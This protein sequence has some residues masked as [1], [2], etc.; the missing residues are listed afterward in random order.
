MSHI[1]DKSQ[2]HLRTGRNGIPIIL[3]VGL[4]LAMM[5]SG[6]FSKVVF[7]TLLGV[8]LFIVTVS[9]GFKIYYDHKL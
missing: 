6:Y 5:I 4:L 9:L 8:L 7:F 1:H 2:A 3:L